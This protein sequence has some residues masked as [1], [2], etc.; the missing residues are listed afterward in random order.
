MCPYR[1]VVALAA[2]LAG[3]TNLHVMSTAPLSTVARLSSLT[4]ADIDVSLLRVAARLPVLLPPGS[5]GAVVTIVRPGMR[6]RPA[7]DETF[8][9]EAVTE[10]KEMICLELMRMASGATC[11]P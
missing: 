3:C 2:L 1:L 6:N 10:A 5:R 4:A 11:G 9:L 7:L 8:I